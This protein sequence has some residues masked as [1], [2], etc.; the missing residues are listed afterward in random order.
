[1]EIQFDQIIDF[2]LQRAIKLY[3]SSYLED[4]TGLFQ[5]ISYSI[6][7]GSIYCFDSEFYFDN[8]TRE[9]NSSYPQLIKGLKDSFNYGSSEN[10]YIIRGVA[11][12]GKTLF[13]EKGLQQLIK[14]KGK[15]TDKY[16]KLGVDFRNIDNDET[17]AFYEQKIYKCLCDNAI[18]DILLLGMETYKE[19]RQVYDDFGRDS[20]PYSYLFPVKYFCE[21]IYE[22]YNKPCVIIFDNIDLASVKTQKNVFKATANVCYKFHEFISHA[23]I[24]DCYRV[25]FAMRPETHLSS[26]EAKLGDVTNF[27][28]PNLLRI[29]LKTIKQA[30]R[31]NAKELDNTSEL[32]CSVTCYDIVNLNNENEMIT[33]NSYTK[34]ADY[35]CSILDKYLG[36]IW[37]ESDQISERL[38][39]CEEF[40]CNIVNYNVRTFMRFMADTIRNGGFKPFTKDF[41]KNYYSVFDYVEMI[42][43]GRWKVHPGNEHIDHEGGNTAPIIFNIFDTGMYTHDQDE[44]IKLFMLNICILQFLLYSAGDRAKNYADIKK[45]LKSI[46]SEDRIHMAIQELI[47]V[48]LL[49]SHI[50]GDSAIAAKESFRQV[51]V[52]DTTK[53]E[54]SHSG[55]FY[56]NKLIYEFEYLYQIALSAPMRIEFVNELKLTWANEK[57]KTVLYFLISLLDITKENIKKYDSKQLC[58]YK[59]IFYLHNSFDHHPLI[60]MIESFCS[61]MNNKVNRARK[62]E[63]ASLHKLIDVLDRAQELKVNALSY[64]EQVFNEW[65]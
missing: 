58:A 2:Q 24:Q 33:L 25:Y 42:I 6:D 13:F 30:L 62:N 34:V 36:E 64:F 57:E 15:H 50:E 54:L 53:L 27:P 55:R 43:R 60:K 46:Y 52:T 20:T 38:G 22:K 7:N 61:V 40:H 10:I 11:G 31:E 47:Y 28:L 1:M 29:F 56:I 5:K 48:R 8:S 44:K 21:K 16:I 17:I 37:K 26:N 14:I 39:N 32:K 63:T 3:N 65:E 35:F 41:N 23:G 4:L 49:Y 12:I 59:D 18:D 9:P 19:F 51:N 45:V